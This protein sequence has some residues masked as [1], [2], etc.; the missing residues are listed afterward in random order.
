[1]D[2]ISSQSYSPIN[3]ILAGLIDSTKA[4]LPTKTDTFITIDTNS[5]ILDQRN[6]AL[7]QLGEDRKGYVLF[8]DDCQQLASSY[9]I[10][11]LVKTWERLNSVS[12]SSYGRKTYRQP[13]HYL[14]L[15]SNQMA[16]NPH[17]IISNTSL[18]AR[19]STSIFTRRDIWRDV[20]K[21][22]V[23]VPGCSKRQ[24]YWMS[25]CMNR[26]YGLGLDILLLQEPKYI[27]SVSS[28][29][30]CDGV[31]G[32]ISSKQ[33]RK[34][35]Q[36]Q[37][38]DLSVLKREWNPSISVIIPFYNVPSETWF[39]QTLSSIAAQ[40]FTDFEII[41][42]NDGS[43]RADYN[44]FVALEKFQNSLSDGKYWRVR[45]KATDHE[46]D[47]PVSV[48]HHAVNLGLAE[49]RNTGV[50]TAR[51]TYIIFLDPDDLL[52]KTALEK[53]VL[54]AINN[55]GKSIPHRG[56]R[57]K[58]GFVYSGTVHFGRKDDVVFSEYSSEALLRENY[59]TATTLVSRIAYLEVGGMCP[60]T[61][62]R[63]FEDFDFWLRML[64]MVSKQMLNI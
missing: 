3:F 50:K 20:F 42:V 39:D 56:D 4:H 37:I 48:V 63:Y 29:K 11:F 25:S 14:H 46:I 22:S 6:I 34:K 38:N 27:P 5:S 35:Q 16:M 49:A 18:M 15:N 44:S 45:H 9:S 2:S 64:S 1:M 23:S 40:T 19:L 51:G 17:K 13:I 41:I 57:E 55:V 58:Y 53:L 26:A 32:M 7:E 59:I 54:F 62:I 33:D 30:K 12:S 8:L 24:R 52:E 21:K 47:I 61:T 60:R 43:T 31:E 28:D 36:F 10:G